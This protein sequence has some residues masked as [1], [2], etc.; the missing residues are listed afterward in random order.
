MLT[1][2]RNA[3]SSIITYLL[4]EFDGGGTWNYNPAAMS[5][6]RYINRNLQLPDDASTTDGCFNGPHDGYRM[7]DSERAAL[8][9]IVNWLRPHRPAARPLNVLM[10]D[11]FNPGW[12]R[13][14]DGILGGQSSRACRRAR[15]RDRYT[16]RTG[17]APEFPTADVVWPRAT[18]PSSGA[19]HRQVSN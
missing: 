10:D 11:S 13:D 9:A 4:V 14:E 5:V 16:G 17:T 6:V 8:S 18:N 15:F 7:L 1:D 3:G 12:Q 2:D 19:R